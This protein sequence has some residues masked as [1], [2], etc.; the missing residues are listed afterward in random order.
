M[1]L[2][3]GTVAGLLLVIGLLL[4]SCGGDQ[5]DEPLGAPGPMDE[6]IRRITALLD[7]EPQWSDAWNIA[8]QDTVRHGLEAVADGR[9]RDV[10]GYLQRVDAIIRA[11]R[12]FIPLA[13]INECVK[14]ADAMLDAALIAFIETIEQRAERVR[15]EQTV[16]AD[17]GWALREW[18][19]AVWEPSNEAAK[20]CFAERE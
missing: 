8:R 3:T 20:A 11:V 13:P 17:D 2:I 5:Q 19:V 14:R 18:S 10:D 15:V 12:G 4:S 7:A 1:N 6:D 16:S 9:D